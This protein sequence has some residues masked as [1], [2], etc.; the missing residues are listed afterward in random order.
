MAFYKQ[1]KGT[2]GGL[3][4][5]QGIR[6]VETVPEDIGGVAW[7]EQRRTQ[8]ASSPLECAGRTERRERFQRAVDFV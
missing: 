6:T 2:T 1:D 7:R 4:I 8:R 3:P 5:G